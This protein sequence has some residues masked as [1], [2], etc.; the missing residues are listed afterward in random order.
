[1]KKEFAFLAG[2]IMLLMLAACGHT[3]QWKEADCLQPKTCETCGQTEGSA[4]GHDWSEATCINPRRCLRCFETEGRSLGHRWVEATCTE[5]RTCS[6]CG[7][8]E[9]EPLGHVV[10]EWTTV[11]EPNC[12]EEGVRTGTCAVCERVLRE[13]IEMTDHIPGE[14]EI[15]LKPTKNT[16]GARNR[17]CTVCGKELEAEAYSIT[18][19]ELKADY[20]SQCV[21]YTF[22]EIARDPDTYEGTYGSYKGEIIQVLESGNYYNLRV[23]ITEQGYYSTYYTDTIF[24]EYTAA[25]GESRLLEGDIVV[26]YG[27]NGGLY[28]YKSAMG[29]DITLPCVYAE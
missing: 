29:V 11:K 13:P 18:P 25:E 26:I 7:D 21:P 19:E 1:M 23:N 6:V 5:A 12:M 15:V 17:H 4:L 3:H 24:V 20:I 22:K 8:T 28:T 14:W 16:D 2:T 27:M 9:G 10:P